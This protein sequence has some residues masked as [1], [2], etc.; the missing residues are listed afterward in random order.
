VILLDTNVLSAVMRTADEPNVE[1]WLDAQ[2][3]DSVW[4]TTVTMFEIRFGLVLLARGRRRERLEAAFARA[5]DEILD[6]RVLPF[7]RPAAETAAALAAERRRSGRPIEIRDVQ[8]AGIAKARRA[9]LAT[10][11]TRHFEALGIQLV[12]PWAA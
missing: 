6:G 3:P 10:R 1:R 2:P 4:T 11:N 7:D 12:D 8:I 5:I 9:T